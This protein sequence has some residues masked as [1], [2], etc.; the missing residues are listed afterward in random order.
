MGAFLQQQALALS[1][2]CWGFLMQPLALWWP[3]VVSCNT[4]TLTLLWLT[5]TRICYP[6]GHWFGL[7]LKAIHMYI[8]GLPLLW[9]SG[10][11]HTG[12]IFA[13][14]HKGQGHRRRME[15]EEKAKVLASVWGTEFIKFVATLA[16]LPRSIWKNRTNSTVSSKLTILL[17]W[18]E[19]SRKYDKL[20]Q[21]LNILKKQDGEKKTY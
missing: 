3:V 10:V 1:F 4:Q 13:L 16:I 15:T 5:V 17:L 11:S 12:N 18:S 21:K 6:L 2:T 8:K 14:L 9:Q 20:M 7:Y 19:A